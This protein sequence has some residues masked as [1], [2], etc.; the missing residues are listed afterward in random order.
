M[1]HKKAERSKSSQKKQR[2]NL[3]KELD[4]LKK[5][6]KEEQSKSND[7]LDKLKYLQ[8]E[9][10]NSQKQTEKEIESSVRAER[11]KLLL[12]MIEIL[13]ELEIAFDSGIKSKSGKAIIK[14]LEL[15]LRK[16][17]DTLKK[18]GLS[19]I[20]AIGKPLDPELH[21]AVSQVEKNQCPDGTVVEEIKKGY[22]LN[23]KLLRPSLVCVAK[24]RK[25]K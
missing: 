19:E 3:K 15:I 22:I 4:E 14:G 5:N 8:A 24:N 16:F 7:Y 2:I 10:E 21:E 18:E 23:G 17:R 1:K 12:E 11:E 9:F 25:D 20:D 6:L 13:D